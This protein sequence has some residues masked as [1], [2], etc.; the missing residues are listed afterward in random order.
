MSP[1]ILT[2]LFLSLVAMTPSSVKGCS[3]GHMG[4]AH[5]EAGAH[6]A[7]IHMSGLVAA[8]RA[9]LG[10]LDYSDEYAAGDPFFG[11][12]SATWP[13]DSRRDSPTQETVSL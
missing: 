13:T 7:L 10:L 1:I 9:R 6:E 5:I 2:S 11:P 3:A 12:P 8:S 4:M